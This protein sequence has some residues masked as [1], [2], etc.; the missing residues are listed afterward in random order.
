[1]MLPQGW[2]S[3]VASRVIAA[4]STPPTLHGLVGIA[5][6]LAGFG[7][8]IALSI[9]SG[10]ASD[11]IVPPATIEAFPPPSHTLLTF[12]RVLIVPSLMEELIWRV[13]L[14]PHPAQVN[15]MLLSAPKALLLLLGVNTCFALYHVL[16]G[17]ILDY[18]SCDNTNA[19][20]LFQK[21]AFLVTAFMLGGAC[22]FSY[23]LA[24]GALF[25]PVLVHAIPVTLW[26]TY[27]WWRRCIKTQ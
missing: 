9:K 8:I 16:G 2:A 24:G 5:S 18:T 7:C 3:L 13:A 12:G 25:A 17:Y 1:M 10:A 27:F 15:G 6:S 22:T 23:Y 11:F 4:S 14:L 26:L 19:L 21:P 20:R